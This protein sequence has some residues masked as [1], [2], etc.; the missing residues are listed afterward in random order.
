MSCLTHLLSRWA[1]LAVW[2]EHAFFGLVR[3]RPAGTVATPPLFL[4]T[5][6]C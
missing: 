1:A 5:K 2:S 6:M 4:N 3:K